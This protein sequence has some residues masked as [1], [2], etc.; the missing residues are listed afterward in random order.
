MADFYQPFIRYN[1]SL[2]M[3]KILTL[4]LILI[5]VHTTISQEKS[6]KE[7][8]VDE[9][10]DALFN[11]DEAIDELMKELSNFEILYV[12]VDYNNDTYFSG[13]DIEIDQYNI[14]P[15]MTYMN[16]KGF[17][18]SL[19]GTYYSEFVPKWDFTS[20]TV[21]YSKSLGKKKLLRAYSSY[22]KYFYSEGVENPFK[23]SLSLGLGIRNKNRTVGTQLVATYLF[24]DDNSIQISSRSYASFKLLKTKKSSLKFKPQLSIVAAKQTFEL[25]QTSF[26]NG[27]LV[28]D[29]LENDVFGL[30]NTQL[31]LPLQFS[32]NAFDIELGYNVNF[33]S[34]L[35]FESNL[36]ST[37]YFNLSLGY[38][39]DL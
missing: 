1:T 8:E 3:K 13:R 10:I 32:N 30:I 29:Y 5:G 6:I 19:S 14:R 28:T 33:P 2:F 27:Q 21:G 4:F 7:K 36:K 25:A 23:N 35:S 15:Q 24:G 26:Q 37:G 9:I 38:M 12:S 16:A 34:E 18:T 11:E 39:I 17:F 31:N 20:V 22:S